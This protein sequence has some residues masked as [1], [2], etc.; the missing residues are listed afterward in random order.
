MQVAVTGASGHIGLNLI[1][2]LCE[3]G[4]AVRALYHNHLRRDLFQQWNVDSRQ[5]DICNPE[6]LTDAFTNCEIVYHLA[7]I[8]SVTNDDRD[9]VFD[10]NVNGAR[11]VAKAAL[12]QNVRRL[13]HTSSVHAFNLSPRN[14]TLDETRA[15]ADGPPHTAYDL[16]KAKG[17]AAVREL[18]SEGLDAVIIHP[19]GVIGPLDFAPSLM[20]QSLLAYFHRKLPGNIAGGF[21]WVHMQD[22]VDMII[23]AGEKGR[24]NESYLVAGHWHSIADIAKM[25]SSITGV[26][27]PK[28]TCPI[29]LARASLP[30]LSAWWKLTKQAPLYTSEML[31]MLTTFRVID[32]G[33]ARRELG[34]NPRSIHSAIE[35]FFTEMKQHV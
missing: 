23:A 35:S 18:V 5:V 11:N 34:H 15:R 13:I 29:W 6:T 19:T 3:Q 31:D 9:R 10:T 30:I 12:S 33:K 22:V 25:V 14:E 20:G 8:I 1:K 27:A 24:K 4:H 16:S 2:T 21:N 28:L 17:E 26:K 32:D 7:G